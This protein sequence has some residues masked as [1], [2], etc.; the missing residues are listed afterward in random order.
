MHSVSAGSAVDACPKRAYDSPLGGLRHPRG[1]GRDERA[2][3][4]TARLA[5]MERFYEHTGVPAQLVASGG[6]GCLSAWRVKLAIVSW[7]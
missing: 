2:D 3:R 1:A 5:F 7:D 6:L 4:R